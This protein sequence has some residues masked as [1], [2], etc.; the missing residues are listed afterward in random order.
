MT[1]Y[2]IALLTLLGSIIVQLLVIGFIL[3][4]NL[5]RVRDRLRNIDWATDEIR[6]L[7]VERL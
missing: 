2:E 3:H 7:F 5:G 1:L 6:R 4:E